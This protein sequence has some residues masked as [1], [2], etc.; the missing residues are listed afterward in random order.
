MSHKNVD[1]KE[2]SSRVLEHKHKRPG[3]RVKRK[4]EVWKEVFYV[5]TIIIP[6]RGMFATD[7]P[8]R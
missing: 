7:N 4:S 3:H 1:L 6:L 5:K 8:G 2:V